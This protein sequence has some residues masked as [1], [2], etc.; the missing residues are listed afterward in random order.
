[1]TEQFDYLNIPQVE[2]NDEEVWC[3]IGET[4][5]LDVFNWEFVERQAAAYDK[6][7]ANLPRDNAQIICKLAVLIRKQTIQKCMEVLG[8]YAEHTPETSVVFINEPKV[9]DDV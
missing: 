9:D 3:T 2:E 1:M 4:G 5:E 8:K 6:H 7:P